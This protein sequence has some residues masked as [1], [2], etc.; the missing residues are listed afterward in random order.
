MRH[1]FASLHRRSHQ[2]PTREFLSFINALL[3][4]NK[5]MLWSVPVLRAL[6]YLIRRWAC[7]PAT[8]RRSRTPWSSSWPSTQRWISQSASLTNCRIVIQI[9]TWRYIL[10]PFYRL[11]LLWMYNSVMLTCGILLCCLNYTRWFFLKIISCAQ[12]SP[13]IILQFIYC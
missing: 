1:F 4:V 10:Y 7:R 5:K 3:H 11:G 9:T 6:S 8:S 2:A 13:E 12:L